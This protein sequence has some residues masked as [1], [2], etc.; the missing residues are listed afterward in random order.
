VAGT[1]LLISWAV[2]ALPTTMEAA[3]G[4]TIEI[5]R[6]LKLAALRTDATSFFA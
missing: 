5:E 4:N 3:A 2:P 1:G 6:R